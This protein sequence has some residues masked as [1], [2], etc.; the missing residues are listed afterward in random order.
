MRALFPD[1]HVGL[2]VH[3]GGL[4]GVEEVVHLRG[5]LGARE[6]LDVG[7]V[8]RV[9][10]GLARGLVLAVAVVL[11][12]LGHAGVVLVRAVAVEV[13]AAVPGVLALAGADVH[14][15]DP[16]DDLVVRVAGW[17][18]LVGTA[19]AAAAAAAAVG[20]LGV[21]DRLGLLRLLHLGR[22]RRELR[23]LLL[24]ELL[25]LGEEGQ[26]RVDRRA[27]AAASG[28]D[29]VELLAGGLRAQHRAEEG[30]RLVV[31]RAR[32][33]LALDF[34]PVADGRVLVRDGLHD[35]GLGGIAGASF[36]GQVALHARQLVD[37]RGERRGR[38]L[39][40]DAAQLDR[41]VLRLHE[42]LLG[43]VDLG[44]EVGEEDQQGGAA[45]ARLV[46]EP[47]GVV[48]AEDDVRQD[49]Q[50]GVV[51]LV[52]DVG[53]DCVVLGDIFRQRGLVVGREG[54]AAGGG[55]V[56]VEL[57]DARR[58]DRGARVQDAVL[59]LLVRREALEELDGLYGGDVSSASV[60]DEPV[61][62]DR[63]VLPR[64]DLPARD[65]VEDAVE[66]RVHAVPLDGGVV[67][68]CWAWPWAI[69]VCCGVIGCHGAHAVDRLW[70]G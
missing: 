58:N 66:V 29:V 13:L 22:E 60:E 28:G 30:E 14:A 10:G 11:E 35:L 63:P 43:V 25:L 32:L 62:G 1:A 27:A 46:R 34:E 7:D 70:C 53:V 4:R 52:D 41:L 15:L 45:A 26:G 37:V 57:A 3:S 44:S 20:L 2:V 64:A 59:L 36:L 40:L 55:H 21:L 48:R 19:A 42:G 68:V 23:G 9:V 8:Q 69:D 56:V 5:E 33:R 54:R 67:G 16:A 49:V 18:H 17:L 38:E 50:E 6:A 65:L 47:G 24:E 31:G 12:A 51:V 39:A 61:L